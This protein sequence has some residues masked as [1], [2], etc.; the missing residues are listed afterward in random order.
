MALP[1]C[2]NSA[3]SRC[4]F[5]RRKSSFNVVTLIIFS[6]QAFSEVYIM[7]GGGPANSTLLYAVNL[8]N[9]AFRDY[10]MGYASALAWIMFLLILGLTL[11][12][13]KFLSGRVIYER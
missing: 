10:A 5:C 9:R 12:I 4:R 1:A 2:R 8:Y 3:R 7:T 6:L 11:I 13:F